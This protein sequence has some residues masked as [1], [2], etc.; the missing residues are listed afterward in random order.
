MKP[1]PQGNQRHFT[2]T[3]P[4]HQDTWKGIEVDPNRSQFQLALLADYTVTKSHCLFSGANLC[5]GIC[6]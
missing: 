1:T 3:W 6:C 5:N 4:N 2:K